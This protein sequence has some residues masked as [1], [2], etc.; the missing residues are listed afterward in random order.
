ML[1]QVPRVVRANVAPIDDE[2]AE[3]DSSREV[4]DVVSVS[5][6]VVPSISTPYFECSGPR[7]RALR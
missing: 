3:S 1:Q 5:L 6:F 7:L 2:G 4:D